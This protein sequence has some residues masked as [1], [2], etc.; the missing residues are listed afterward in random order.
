MHIHFFIFWLGRCKKRKRAAS[1]WAIFKGALHTTEVMTA[2]LKCFD[3]AEVSIDT[4]LSAKL[5]I[6]NPPPVPGWWKIIHGKAE[7]VSD[8]V[9]VRCPYTM[10]SH[11]LSPWNC[12]SS[13][14]PLARPPFYPAGVCPAPRPG[15]VADRSGS[16]WGPGWPATC[17]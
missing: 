4:N 9:T 17:G 10:T 11:Y 15:N 8:A 13:P 2:R 1:R 6:S 5:E 12:W 7:V 3:F 16:Q 14:I